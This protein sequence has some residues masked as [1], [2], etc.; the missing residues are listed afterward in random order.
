MSQ[1]PRQIVSAPPPAPGPAGSLPLVEELASDLDPWDVCLRL[2]TLPHFLFLDSG[3]GDPAL[4]R[5]S[6][7]TADPVSWFVGKNDPFQWRS[8]VRSPFRRETVPGLPP[9]QGGLAGM[10]AYDCCHYVE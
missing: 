4:G 10:W 7:I 1:Q 5:Y 2:S 9:F 3:G 8:G 6:F